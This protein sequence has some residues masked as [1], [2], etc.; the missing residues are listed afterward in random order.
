MIVS[1]LPL[2]RI[3][4][5]VEYFYILSVIAT[6]ICALADL[7][8]VDE[9]IHRS[10]VKHLQIQILLER[11][12]PLYLSGVLLFCPFQLFLEQSQPLRLRAYSKYLDRAPER[13]FFHTD[14]VK[15]ARNP[16][17]IPLLFSL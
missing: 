15:N 14:S 17:R 5:S 8:M 12:R 11:R 7:D 9:L 2:C 6:C 3:S 16:Q 10:P 1:I 4:E 13:R